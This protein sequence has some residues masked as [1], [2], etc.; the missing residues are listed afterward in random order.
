M[1]GQ[2]SSSRLSMRG[3]CKTFGAT[4]ALDGVDFDVGT[5]VVHAL[6]GENG[7]GKS[8]LMKILS[9]A[10]VPDSGAMVLDGK[11]YAPSNTHNARQA[12]VAMIYQEL[13]LASHLSVA[14]NILLGV[15][16]HRC[17][18]IRRSEVLQRTRDALAQLDH[19][20]IPAD[21]NVG[22]LPLAGRQVVEIARALATGCRVLILDEPTSSLSQQDIERLFAIVRRLSSEGTSIIYISHILEEVKQVSDRLTVLRDGRSVWTGSTAETAPDAIIRHMVGRRIDQMYPRSV[23]T[24][25]EPLLEV[26][27]LGGNIKPRSAGFSLHRG[28]VLGIAGLVGAGRT[29]LL[30]VLFGLDPIRRGAIR[31]GMYSGYADPPTRWAQGV[32]MVSE[33]RSRE[34]LALQLTIVDN[35]TMNLSKDRQRFGFIMPKR[36]QR[37]AADLIQLLA[38]RSSGPLQR[39]D[40]LSGG[41]QQKVALARLLHEDVDVVLLDEPT[42]GIDVSSKSQLYALIDRMA[43]GDPARGIKPKAIL[44]V[45][46]YLPELLGIC[47]RVAVMCRGVLGAP[48]SVS[49]VDQHSLMAEATGQGTIA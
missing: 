49:E 5:G 19:G 11:P 32:G 26:R 37:T 9:G 42:R 43:L 29:E 4:V 10:L 24:F 3:I 30:R 15:E 28:E 21:I 38:I 17:G 45:S 2:A 1:I 16:P 14:E 46:S 44:I 18:F 8:T 31:V 48:K 35:I 25:G 27:D 6:V 23:H 47:D 22:Q 13:S 12:G 33:D 39:V 36:L 41:N 40:S 7:A 34:G 20:D